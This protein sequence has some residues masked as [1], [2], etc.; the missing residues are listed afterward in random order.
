MSRRRATQSIVANPVLVGAVT[1][2]V[3]IVAVFLAYNA[4]NGLPFVPTK[5]IKVQ[6]TSGS[7][8][9]KGN[10][11]REGGY[12]IGVVTDLKP[13]PLSNG[14]IGAEAD[15]KLDKAAG[16]VPADSRVVVRPRSALGLKYLELTRGKS[17]KNLS[18]GDTLPVAQTNVPV[19]FDEIFK[20]FDAP[21]RTAEQTNLTGF[22]DAFAGRGNDINQAITELPR[23]FGLLAPVMSNL[24]APQTNLT[25]FFKELDDAARIIAPV[26][27]VNARFFAVAADT[28]EA[29]ARDPAAL[30]ATISKSPSTLA[31]GEVSFREQRPFLEDTAAFSRD[32][33]FTAADLRAGLP[34]I[35]SALEIG[36]PVVRRTAKLNGQLQ[37]TMKSLQDLVEAPTTNIAIRGLTA[38]VAT[39]NP[40]LRYL[41][42]YV[43]VCNYWNYFWTFV[44]DHFSEKDPTGQSQRALVNTTDNQKYGISSGGAAEPASGQPTQAPGG[45][46]QNLHGQPYGAAINPDGTA[47]C[48][49]V[50]R[51]YPGKLNRYGKGPYSNVTID[52]YTPGSQGPT[53]KTFDD[54]NKPLSQRILGPDRPPAGETFT[55]YPE[56]GPLLSQDPPR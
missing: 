1:T 38:T 46:S 29:F 24:G 17:S 23:F 52:T 4:N 34:T 31:A 50:Q 55:R 10:E 16:D 22:G 30:Q 8:L 15:L 33:R 51:G 39:L 9:V 11:V 43:T 18:D 44:A 6:L 2:L 37:K 19:Q 47:D 27:A 36:T 14:S 25:R 13:I 56:T 12:R 3:V 41:G 32:L 7:N 35:N 28:F 48:E 53:F 42:P 20:I 40:Q 54:V 21:T 49:A 45:T 5:E 26:A